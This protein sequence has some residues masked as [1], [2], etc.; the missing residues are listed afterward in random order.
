MRPPEEVRLVLSY[1]ELFAAIG[2]AI[3]GLCPFFGDRRCL[4]VWL[5]GCLSVSLFVCPVALGTESRSESITV[6]VVVERF[7]SREWITVGASTWLRDSVGGGRKLGDEEPADVNYLA[8]FRVGFAHPIDTFACAR[9]GLGVFDSWTKGDMGWNW[10]LDCVDSNYRFCCP[11][12]SCRCRSRRA[13]RRL[14]NTLGVVEMSYR[15]R[16]RFFFFFFWPRRGGTATGVNGCA[17]NRRSLK[18]SELSR[19]QRTACSF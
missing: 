18:S 13:G 15:H 19:I 11:L 5:S 14:A 9:V 1:P 2:F 17:Y 12:G 4:S 6:G 8:L 7:S 16:A 3:C 10:C